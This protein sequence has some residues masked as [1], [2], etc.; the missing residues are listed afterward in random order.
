MRFGDHE[1]HTAV[2]PLATHTETPPGQAKATPEFFIGL[3]ASFTPDP[4]LDGLTFWFRELGVAG[5]IEVAP[6]GQVLQTLLSPTGGLSGRPG[7]HVVLLRLRDW[8]RELPADH[9]ASPDF[10]ASYL[11]AAVQ[12]H[13]RAMRSHRAQASAETLLVLCPSA[14]A[15]ADAAEPLLR[16]AEADLVAKLTGLPGL[17]VVRADAFHEI[18]EVD[19]SQI[20]DP[21]REHIA[22]IPYQAAYFHT[23]ATVVMRHVHR[24]LAPAR[25]V[26]AVDCDNTLWRGVV[27]EVGAEGLVF[28]E[29]HQALHETLTRLA[30]DGVL[31]ALCSKNEEPDVWR[32]FESRADC[33]LRRES[34]VASAINWQPKS[35]NLRAMADRLNLGLDSFVFI[36]DNPVECAEVRAAC[37]EILTLEW[38]QDA[39]QAIR[40]L[41]HTWELDARGATAEDRRRTE[42]YQEEFR[43]QELQAQTLTF[44]DFIASLGLIVDIAPLAPEDLK[45]ASQLT[46][47]TNQF[48]FT[49]KRREET[50]LQAL[51]SAGDHEIRTVRVRD[52]FGDYGLVG[53][54]IARADD[55]EV[56]ADTFLLSCRVLGRGVEHQMVAE[57]GRIAQT[58]GASRVRLRVEPT[59][60]NTPARSFLEQVAAADLRQSSEGILEAVLPAADVAA[61]VFEPPEQAGPAVADDRGATPSAP[62]NAGQLRSREAQIQRTA[63]DLS[64]PAGLS[65]AIDGRA[66]PSQTGATGADAGFVYDAFAAAL[67]VSPEHVKEVDSLEALGC[68]SFKIVEITVRL[69]ERFPALPRTLL[70]EHRSVSAI[71]RRIVELTGDEAGAYD[72]QPVPARV[73]SGRGPSHT[74]DIAVVGMHLRTA[75]AN[76]P[77]ELWDLLSRGGV[78][79]TP[80]PQGRKYFFGQL[81]DE[82]GH[83]A[84]LLDDI[85][86]FD[87]ELFGI[88]PREAELM[89]PQLRLFLEVAW[90]ALEDAGCLGAALDPETGVFAG[91]MYG[92][93]AYRANLV[94]KETENPFKCW[95]GFS[96]AN[97]LSHIFG[98]RGPSLAVDTACS[99][100]GT[101]IHLACRALAAGD[102]GVAVAGGVNLLLDPDR[103]VQLGRLGILSASGRCLAFGATADGTV[104]G[105]GAGVVVLRPL[106]D[107][108]ARGDRIYGIIK[109]TALSTGSGSIGFTAPDPIAQAAAI[110]RAVR[111]AGLDP[112]TISY[113]ETHGT[114][115]V[116][117]DPIE[118]RGLTLA[119]TDPESWDTAVRGTQAC[120]LG[121]IKPNIGHLEAGAAV[122]GLIKVLLQLQRRT[123]LPSVTS[124]LPN[125]QIPFDETPFSI[126]RTL[127]AW[128]PPVLE[129]A[130]AAVAAPRRAALNSFG[131]GGANAHIIIEEAPGPATDPEPRPAL[132][133]YL[134]AVSARNADS[135]GRRAGDIA[136]ALDTDSSLDPADVCYSVNT[137][138]RTLAQR[139]AITART[140]DEMI[141]ALRQLAAGDEPSGTVTGAVPRSA[142]APQVAFL[143]TGQGS[144]YAGMGRDLYDTHPVFRLALDRCFELFAPLLDRDLRDVMFA[145]VDSPEAALLNQTGFTQPALFSLGY[146]LSALWHSWGVRPA[147][148]LGHSIG[149]ITAMCVAGGLSLEDAVTMVAAR[150]RLMQ[151]L[152]PGGGMTS[153]M[154][155]EAR[156]LGA[157]AGLEDRV[158]IAAINGPEQIVMSGDADAVA[159][160]A[161]RFEADGV[162]TR[163]LVVSHAFHSPLMAPMLA[164]YEAVLRRIRFREPRVVFVGCVPGKLADTEVTQPEY[165]L[166]NVMAPVRFADAMRALDALGAGAFVEAGP[167]PVLLGMGRQCLPAAADEDSGRLWLPSIRK[168]GDA[169][170]VVL[171]S[172]G[173]LY[174]AGAPIDWA[175]FH[176]PFAGR[177]VS[178]PA[179]PFGG[180]RY[181][182]GHVPAVPALGATAAEPAKAGAT[183]YDIA[184][185]PH[186]PAAGAPVQGDWVI[187]ADRLGVGA[188]L[189]RQLQ[190]AGARCTI[191][192]PDSPAVPALAPDT[193]GIV[194]LRGLDPVP[195]VSPAAAAAGAAEDIVAVMRDVGRR[196]EATR[197]WMVTQG[198]VRAADADARIDV[199]QGALWGAG[200]TFALEHPSQWGGLIDLA[201]GTQ[202]DAAAGSIA[203]I[204]GSSD[205]EDQV[206]IRGA[207]YF[208][209]RLVPRDAASTIAFA[210]SPDGTY[211]V[212]GGL[213]ALGRHTARW[214]VSRGARHLVLTSRRGLLTP[215][216]DEVVRELEALGARVRVVSADMA[217]PHDVAGV[218]ES[219][220]A[221]APLAGIFH[222]AGIDDTRAI[223]E[224][225]PGD[226]ERVMAAKATGAW[227]LHDNTKHL[228][229]EAF[230]CFSSIASALGSAGR[231]AYAAA[232]AF[233]DALAGER[234]L[235]GLPALSVNWG[236]WAGGGMATDSALEQYSRVGNRGLAPADAIREME[237][238]LASGATQAA[239]ADID[240]ATFRTAYEARRTRPLIAELDVPGVASLPADGSSSVQPPWVARLASLDPGRRL[241]ELTTL[242][243]GEI[244][245]T[246]G[247]QGADEVAVDR[248]FRDMGMDSL[249]S[250]D[251][252]QRLQKRLGIRSTALLFDHPAVAL[253]APELLGNLELA[254]SPE[255]EPVGAGIAL[256]GAGGAAVA[257]SSLQEV[258]TV[259]RAHE[260]ART[261]GY[262]P[263]I[264]DEVFAFQREAWPHRRPDWIAPRWRWMFVESARRLDVSPQVWLHRQ[265]GAIVGHNGAIPVRL[266]IGDEERTTAWLVETMVLEAYRSQAVGARLTAE[267]H[268]DL[269]FGLSLG[270]TEQMRAIQ[271]RLG[272]QQ[273]TPLQTAM[274]MLRPERVLRSKLPGPA[275]L[276][277]GLAMRASDAVRGAF[278]QRPRAQVRAIAG[279]DASHDRIWDAMQA[280]VTCA[281]RRDASYLNWKYVSQPGQDFLRLEV[282]RHD[283]ARGLIV[284][285]FREPGGNYAYRRAF[286]VD[287]VAPL[288]DAE[289]LRDLLQAAADAALERG[290][291]ALLCLHVG[292]ALT[293]ALE[294]SGYRMR[295]PSR[296]LLVRPGPLEGAT[297]ERLLSADGWFVT[298]GDSDIDRP[299]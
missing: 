117:G 84:G 90:G 17:T 91:A 185:R 283:G 142:V 130:G 159:A 161:S 233:L 64:T 247:F 19:G 274:L 268:E 156:V 287:V 131:V 2:P 67:K 27:G 265:G 121:S 174:V 207:G 272:W 213:G 12:D 93:Y 193:R 199:A 30:G 216:A 33:T 169:W 78:A 104:F 217:Q 289:L 26:V 65:R 15:Q 11:E 21:V 116:L 224:M 112:R 148:V 138:Q 205:A 111:V 250:A 24:R 34:I 149:E 135:L 89:D 282:S 202:P 186:T 189:A 50:D 113:V 143:F 85:D 92:D 35:A 165:W 177:R 152:P 176:A 71:A 249:M 239:V 187:L 245:Q 105:E 137:G 9:A 140:R 40:L 145:A 164:D 162:K 8:L 259:S 226:V 52:R 38:P 175:G 124:D 256:A 293:A 243:R 215:G 53:L 254:G 242:L 279:F 73:Q 28:D 192:G 7:M 3:S 204:V 266:K 57:L 212:T 253:L 203:T 108:R 22:H 141:A 139:A 39:Q 103:F 234:R 6:Y 188:A 123:L 134:L 44:R 128:D 285:M 292:P 36:D 77:S 54:L 261:D 211:L 69:L 68:D 163:A 97:R 271:F 133:Q 168:D 240:W 298:H 225:H 258:A 37:P 229:L 172:L 129:V 197:L 246:L 235:A 144:Q 82:R 171:G 276:A 284:L 295:Q 75:G 297:R 45:R 59:K 136:Q 46:L 208:V 181:W 4:I 206:A 80:V 182:I 25:K 29:A 180:R 166:R 13:E 55:D 70:F 275:A 86:R 277:A 200:R 107:A 244:A 273:V 178:L 42:L 160:V 257:L 31:V 48:N 291:D 118:V 236:P 98:F 167:Q 99:S 223:L 190:R 241:E 154:A 264:E 294:Q 170:P 183:A 255:A 288:S 220:T 270:Q 81:R 237:A 110:R 56:F 62:A 196:N 263:D 47:R 251:F 280:D 155:P 209:P 72:R 51:A 127:A 281:V 109:A 238:L 252:A 262:T 100:S 214:L 14:P 222:T 74:T 290:A 43:R 60:R 146:A 76:S 20:A 147:A 49:T 41:Q 195:G 126:Q 83:F 101:A 219:I 248:P 228:P 115:T 23:L 158:A 231:S 63:F 119:Y 106:A 96:L 150:G 120:T 32:V 267:A 221:D 79:V 232:N 299:W 198:A 153:V 151:A 230:V 16:A 95:E 122:L 278:A 286:I 18:Y 1:V 157:I 102:C 132:P 173:R 201:D 218:L 184:W 227:L 61:L 179:Y 269:P 66:A 125:P 88:T 5:E 94:A 114:G 260:S 210:A 10:L 191:V 194:H 87:A 58:R 296:Y